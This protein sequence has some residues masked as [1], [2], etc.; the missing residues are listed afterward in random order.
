MAAPTFN[1]PSSGGFSAFTAEVQRCL[2]AIDASAVSGNQRNMLHRP[3]DFPGG[4]SLS[5]GQIVVGNNSDGDVARITGPNILY[6]LGR[7]DLT[8]TSA[9]T[10]EL[11][12]A[13][14]RRENPTDA[15]NDAVKF[16][17]RFLDRNKDTVVTRTL[18]TITDLTTASGRVYETFRVAR[19]AGLP[20]D[21][22]APPATGAPRYMMALIIFEGGAS[23]VTDVEILGIEEL[24]VDLTAAEEAPILR[25][26]GHR[27]GDTPGEFNLRMEGAADGVVTTNQNGKVVRFTGV[28]RLLSEA[29]HNIEGDNLYRLNFAFRRNLDSDDPSNDGVRMRVRYFDR[30]KEYLS[31]ATLQSV[32]DLTIASG[33]LTRAFFVGRGAGHP[34]GTIQPPIGACYMG[35]AVDTFG[36]SCRTDIEI[37]GIERLPAL[38]QGEQGV[39]GETGATGTAGRRGPPGAPGSFMGFELDATGSSLP[40]SASNG[41]TFGLISGDTV[42]S[43][44]WLAGGWKLVFPSTPMHHPSY[45][46]AAPSV[47]SIR[48]VGTGSVGP[49]NIDWSGPIMLFDPTGDFISPDDYTRT[50]DTVTFDS[51]IA[52]AAV[53]SGIAFETGAGFQAQAISITGDGTVGP[54]TVPANTEIVIL[55]SPEGQIAQEDYTLVGTDLTFDAAIT[56]GVKVQGIGIVGTLRKQLPDVFDSRAEAIAYAV[57]TGIDTILVRHNGVVLAYRRDVDGEAL[58]TAGGIKWAPAGNPSPLHY[59]APCNGTDDDA[60]YFYTCGLEHGRIYGLGATYHFETGCAWPRDHHVSVIDLTDT[61][62]NLDASMGF[63]PA[64]SIL[65]S[66][67][68]AGTGGAGIL[69]TAAENIAAGVRTIEVADASVLEVGGVYEMASDEYWSGV[70]GVSGFGVQPKGEMIQISEIAGNDI[71]LLTP[72]RDSYDNATYSVR[73]RPLNLLPG[74]TIRGGTINGLNQDIGGEEG[75]LVEDYPTVALIQFARDVTIAGMSTRGFVAFQIRASFC[76]NVEVSSNTFRGPDVVEANLPEPTIYWGKGIE[77]SSCE[78]VRFVNNYGWRLRAPI[79]CLSS[80]TSLICRDVTIAGNA[81]TECWRGFSTHMVE[82]LTVTGNAWRTRNGFYFRGKNLTFVGNTLDIYTTDEAYACG[83]GLA[84]MT[85][86]HSEIPDAGHIVFSDNLIDCGGATAIRVAT[87]LQSFTAEGNVF[88]HCASGVQIWAKYVKSLLLRGNT[89]I[90]KEA[91]DAEATSYGAIV[92]NHANVPLT[93]LGNVEIASNNFVGRW[94]YGVAVLGTASGTGAR[95]IRIITNNFGSLR[96]RGISFQADGSDYGSHGNFAVSPFV[97]DNVIDVEPGTPADNLVVHPAGGGPA[98]VT[99]SRRMG[100][101]QYVARP[102]VATADPLLAVS[103]SAGMRELF[104]T[105][106]AAGYEGRA[107]TAP[108][109]GLTL[110][111]ITGGISSGSPTLVVSSAADIFVGS[112]LT[113]AGSGLASNTRVIAKNGTTLTLSGNAANTVAGAAVARQAPTFKGFGAVQA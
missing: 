88:S 84:P 66:G 18:R 60:P 1:P 83:I 51:A 59:G 47:W 10:Y 42:T 69:T 101:P 102:E 35:V 33:R 8:T 26:L 78:S 90:S 2:N 32:T 22:I 20:S 70:T 12:F 21:V 46:P 93:E 25:N 16:C 53:I 110:S 45:G 76:L 54:Y 105:P 65:G 6:N 52:N 111:G 36:V 3:G 62:I 64:F 103:Y 107:C 19:G 38:A 98:A 41:D 108:G 43:Y 39:P 112:Y 72:T 91:M 4:F 77:A 9:E 13:V 55:F 68:A 40:G 24:A 49:Y 67:L 79:D 81:A 71:T 99:G 109:T 85:V 106:I 104:A 15:A 17:V 94:G 37:A 31:T 74:V 80:S 57:P 50:N 95:R 96:L 48:I 87:S 56:N 23:T 97:D 82:N 92:T 44:V 63:V 7:I 86:A 61:T 73:F 11:R 14:R 34:D 5:S 75:A 89:F 113:V 27:P 29:P 58:T 100:A 28:G 30:L